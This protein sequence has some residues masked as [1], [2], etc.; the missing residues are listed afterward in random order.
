M[1]KEISELFFT[2]TNLEKVLSNPIQ[3]R[4]RGRMVEGL[5][6]YVTTNSYLTIDASEGFGKNR[7]FQMSFSQVTSRGFRVSWLR[8]PDSHK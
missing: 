4:V 1:G 8:Y 3:A 7:E 2:V 6:D 5:K